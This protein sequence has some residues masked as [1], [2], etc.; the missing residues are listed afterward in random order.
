M[1]RRRTWNIKNVT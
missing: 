1:R